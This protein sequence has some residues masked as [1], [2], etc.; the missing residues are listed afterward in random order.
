[1]IVSKA[2]LNAQHPSL[3]WGFFQKLLYVEPTLCNQQ[4]REEVWAAEQITAA[5]ASYAELPRLKHAFCSL[6]LCRAPMTSELCLFTSPACTVFQGRRERAEE[7]KGREVG[8]REKCR[9]G[10]RVFDF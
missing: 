6:I 7:G 5:S 10:F 2:L 8:D 9:A 4:L 3:K 1:M